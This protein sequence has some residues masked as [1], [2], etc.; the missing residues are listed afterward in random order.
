MLES[1][2]LH[3]KGKPAE[4]KEGRSKDGKKGERLTQRP[5]LKRLA[6]TR[7]SSTEQSAYLTPSS[8][9]TQTLPSLS[10]TT[11]ASGPPTPSQPSFWES[12]PTLRQTHTL[13]CLVSS[14]LFLSKPEAPTEQGLGFTLPSFRDGSKCLLADHSPC[15]S[16]TWALSSCTS[17]WLASTK[18][19]PSPALPG[20]QQG[21]GSLAVN[22]FGEVVDCLMQN[23]DVILPPS[24]SCSQTD[25]QV[26]RKVT[27]GLD[28]CGPQEPGKEQ[29][30]SPWTSEH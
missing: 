26:Y 19:R 4:R 16:S 21:L 7:E 5:V 27:L 29:N 14:C 23:C 22:C 28:V 8:N 9:P 2:P 18:T 11:A 1:R 15:A 30:P 25:S 6:F 10:L 24:V 13:S 12:S 20:M 3:Q 17:T